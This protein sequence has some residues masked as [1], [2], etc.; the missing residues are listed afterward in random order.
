MGVIQPTR[1]SEAQ[2]IFPSLLPPPFP[3]ILPFPFLPPILPP[4]AQEPSSTRTT[5]TISAPPLSLPPH[6]HPPHVSSSVSCSPFLPAS[7]CSGA[8]K[9]KTYQE[10]L[11]PSSSSSSSPPLLQLTVGPTSYGALATMKPNA[12]SPSSCSATCA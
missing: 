3:L 2:R 12:S 8:L 9:Y 11:C 5:Q 10:Y 7:P 1:H 4:F 6:P